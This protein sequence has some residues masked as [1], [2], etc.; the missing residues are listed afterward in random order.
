VEEEI[1]EEEVEVE[2]VEEV[3]E[4]VEEEVEEKVEEVVE[5]EEEE[6]YLEEI[7]IDG[8]TYCATGST[9]GSKVYE[10]DEDEQPGKLIGILKDGKI[11]KK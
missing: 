4:I 5:E 2:V 7:V 11:V 10:L 8:V 9:D 1:V 3:E 6:D